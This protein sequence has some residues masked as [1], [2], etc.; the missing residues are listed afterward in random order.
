MIDAL[1]NVDQKK[2]RDT[3]QKNISQWERKFKQ[4]KQPIKK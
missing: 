1:K 2:I 3:K 4:P